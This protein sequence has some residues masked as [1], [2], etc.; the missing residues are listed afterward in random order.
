MKIHVLLT[1]YFNFEGYSKDN[2]KIQQPDLLFLVAL[3]YL[4]QHTTADTFFHKFLELHSALSR[5]KIFI[6]NFLFLNRFTQIPT[7]LKAKIC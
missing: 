6:S 1:L 3:Y 5:K 2:C 4:L 7:P